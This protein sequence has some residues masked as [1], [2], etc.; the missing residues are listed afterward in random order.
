MKNPEQLKLE[1]FQKGWDE[2]ASDLLMPSAVHDKTTNSFKTWE[3]M[4]APL[5][6]F[7]AYRLGQTEGQKYAK[8]VAG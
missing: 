6:V 4:L 3:Q 8:A 1:R 5:T 2:H 7:E